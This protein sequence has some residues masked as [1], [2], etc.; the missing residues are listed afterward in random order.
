MSSFDET[1]EKLKSE[2]EAN[3]QTLKE[4]SAWTQV[5]KLYLALGTIE[6]L[7]GLPKTSLADLFGFTVTNSAS[8]VKGEFMGKSGLD[9]AKLYLDKKKE[10]AASLDEIIDALQ[11]GG[12]NS[13]S[14]D[15]LRKGLARS[16]WDVVKAPGQDLYKLVKHTPNVKRGKG[17]KS[18]Q[19]TEEPEIS[20]ETSAAENGDET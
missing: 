12:A 9:A 17:K 8:V 2:I 20:A 5:E 4:N 14:R 18:G 3:V 19:T 13:I 10:V 16:T 7:S 1:I 11:T 6:E 15:E